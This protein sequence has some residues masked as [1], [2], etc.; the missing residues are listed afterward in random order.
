[1]AAVSLRFNVFWV[2]E[3]QKEFFGSAFPAQNTVEWKTPHLMI[4]HHDAELCWDF[5]SGQLRD[6]AADIIAPAVRQF[7]C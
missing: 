4:A 3:K 5:W 2:D 1:M 7:V 6:V